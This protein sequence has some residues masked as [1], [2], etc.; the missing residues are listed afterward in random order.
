MDRY[1]HQAIRSPRYLGDY[2][3][4]RE[5]LIGQKPDKLVLKPELPC[6]G[7]FHKGLESTVRAA[8]FLLPD[9]SLPCPLCGQVVLLNCS[10]NMTRLATQTPRAF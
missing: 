2:S 8:Q 10:L 3:H 6:A 1:G 4:L 7:Y 5:Q 9:L